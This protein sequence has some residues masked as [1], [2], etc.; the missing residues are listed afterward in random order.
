LHS[1]LLAIA[2]A[3]PDLPAADS[4]LSFHLAGSL[5]LDLDFKQKLL[6]SRSEPERLS[7]LISYFETIIPNLRRATTA[8]AKAG[9]NGHVH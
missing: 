4:L 9:G 7:L 1:E 5:P 3:K 2:G 6:S 8:R